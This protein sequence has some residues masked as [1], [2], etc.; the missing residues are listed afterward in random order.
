M[1]LVAAAVVVAGGVTGYVW[2]DGGIRIG[3]APISRSAIEAVRSCDGRLFN[4]FS[5]GG[6]LTWWVPERRVFV[7]SRGVEAY[8]IE[9]LLRS[10]DVDLTARYETL[11]RNYNISCV[12]VDQG[13][14]LAAALTAD[15]RMRM[16]FS[17]RSWLVMETDHNSAELPAN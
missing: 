5:A 4:S 3:W 14:P 13:S 11:F 6:P 9:L 2:R 1:V 12:F 16:L 7:D 15:S 10:Q 17:D 8:P